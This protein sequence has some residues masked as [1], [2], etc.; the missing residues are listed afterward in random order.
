M[1]R[2]ARGF[3]GYGGEMDGVD[4]GRRRRLDGTCGST[5][6]VL[7]YDLELS[8]AYDVRANHV[9]GNS[10]GLLLPSDLSRTTSGSELSL[11]LLDTAR[12]LSKRNSSI[13]FA[14]SPI[15]SGRSSVTSKSSGGLERTGLCHG[16]SFSL[17]PGI[18][19]HPVGPP[20]GAHTCHKRV[21][22]F[23]PHPV[24][25]SLDRRRLPLPLRLQQPPRSLVTRQLPRAAEA[26]I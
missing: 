11:A 26:S 21:S 25:A 7:M 18:I 8:T 2:R 14:Y 22:R 9:L 1:G 6:L 17:V 13:R 20:A 5:G 10:S 15:A 12:Y 23:Q 3:I 19:P 4:G 24:I 16:L